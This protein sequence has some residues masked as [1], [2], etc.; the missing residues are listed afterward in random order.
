[1][2]K[3]DKNTGNECLPKACLEPLLAD[4]FCFLRRNYRFFILYKENFYANKSCT[5]IFT[6]I[7]TWLGFQQTQ[8]T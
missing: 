3:L 2:L 7:V 5:H 1:M 8:V 4:D 6:W